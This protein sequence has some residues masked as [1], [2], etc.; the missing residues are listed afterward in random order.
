MTNDNDNKKS[1]LVSMLVEGKRYTGH[2]V[3][4]AEVLRVST[5]IGTLS[6]QFNGG[7]VKFLAEQLL[8][9]LVREELKGS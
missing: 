3:L 2:Y 9:R 6:K 8:A 1:G 7:S 5:E 4:E